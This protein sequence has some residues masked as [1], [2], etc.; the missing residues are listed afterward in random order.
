MV[1]QLITEGARG[2]GVAVQLKYNRRILAGESIYQP[3]S[4][5][6]DTETPSAVTAESSDKSPPETETHIDLAGLVAILGGG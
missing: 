3:V 5:G 4:A 6:T 1:G 2:P